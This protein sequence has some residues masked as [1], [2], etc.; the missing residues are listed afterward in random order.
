MSFTPVV[1]LSLYGVFDPKSLE[2]LNVNVMLSLVVGSPEVIGKQVLKLSEDIQ[3]VPEQVVPV[4][5]IVIVSGSITSEKVIDML[6][7]T[8]KL[9]VVRFVLPVSGATDSVIV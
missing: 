2:G 8:G 9:A 4:V 5:M 7:L 1:I 3:I 6:E